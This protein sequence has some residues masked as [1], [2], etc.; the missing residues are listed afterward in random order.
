MVISFQNYLEACADLICFN[1]VGHSFALENEH[2]QAIAA[3]FKAYQLMP[4]CH[5][6]LLY[7]GVEY[8]LTNNV[9][10]AERFFLEATDIAPEDPFVLHELG[11]TCFQNADYE[12]AEKH[13]LKAL[14]Q[15]QKVHQ[16]A[17]SSKWESLLNNLGHTARKLGK[18]EDALSYHQRALVLKPKS[19][20]T[21][22][23]IG[24]TQTLMQRYFEAVESFHK[25]LSLKRDD[26]FSTTMLNNCVEHLVD[27]IT[28][29]TD[30]PNEIPKLATFEAKD[31]TYEN[32]MESTLK[33]ETSAEV[34][35]STDIE[36]SDI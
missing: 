6:P 2:D 25:A 5:L 27:D 29:F 35:A 31:S 11:V 12:E 15:V 9:K 4:G 21:Y 10:L 28:P 14:T 7:I 32:E 26:A 20:S 16:S 23:A 1:F 34:N 8:G 33:S 30:Y 22:S 24:Y 18:L 13:M 17:L 36:M 19:S 3:Y